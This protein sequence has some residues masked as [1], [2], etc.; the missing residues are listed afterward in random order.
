MKPLFILFA[1]VTVLSPFT[2]PNKTY[3]ITGIIQNVSANEPL[4][5]ASILVKN[6]TLGT[7]SNIDGVFSLTTLDS[8]VLVVVSYTGYESKEV[9]ICYGEKNKIQLDHGVQLSEVVVTAMSIRRTKKSLGYG[10]INS[11]SAPS[12]RRFHLN[13]KLRVP[14]HESTNE[15]YADIKENIFRATHLAPQSTF[16]IDVDAASYS[17]IRRFLNSSQLPPTD[18]VRIE[19]MINYFNYSYPQPKDNSP[20]AV[21]TEFTPC[22]WQTDHLLL[23][24]GIQGQKFPRKNIPASNIVFLLDVS[25]SMG[26]SDKLPLLKESLKMLTDNLREEDKVSIVVYADASG[27]VLEPT[28][29][30]NKAKIREALDKLKS[31]GSTAGAAGIELA[32]K[33][34]AQ[35]F[36]EGGNNRVILATD[37]DFNVGIS[38]ND[39]LVELIEEKRK[40]GVFLS[41]L[42]FGTGNIQDDKME[43]L[44]DKGNGN[45]AYIDNIKEARKVLVT[46]FGGTLFTIAKDVKIQVDFNSKFVQAYRLIGYENRLL[47]NEDFAD[48]T[49]DAGELGAGHTVTALYEIIPTG[50]HTDKDFST[51]TIPTVD[52]S[53][54]GLNEMARVKLRYKKP[55]ENNSQLI[56]H[57]LNKTNHLDWGQCSTNIRWAAVVAEFGMLLRDS[58]H[59][60]TATYAH[61]EQMAREST[62]R[63]PFGYRQEMVDLI[64]KAKQMSGMVTKRE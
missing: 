9:T 3:K 25:G 39:A 51:N 56:E 43:S 60:G 12:P 10:I 58:A 13:R 20:F 11:S 26:S 45:Y 63:D 30:N 40:T 34:A 22:P 15:S 50:L 14:Q 6:T 46:E 2:H 23:H 7:V 35:E 33:M 4:I 64:G 49:K 29:G 54:L 21:V 61:C 8:C 28:S 37:G 5:G 57:H 48:D 27:L 47:N 59:K 16:S 36:I 53:S 55:T 18:A 44:A 17:N 42:G 38:S 1:L 24:V 31:G 52:F 41:V 32:Y 62:G 19:E